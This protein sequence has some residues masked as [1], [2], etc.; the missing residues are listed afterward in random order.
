MNIRPLKLLPSVMIFIS[1]AVLLWIMTHLLIPFLTESTGWE[2]V[3]FWFISGGLGVFTPLIVA[4]IIMLHKEGCKFTK[5]LLVERLRFRPMTRRD[6]RFSYVALL[7]IGILTGG[8]MIA[9]QALVPDFNHTPSFMTLEPLSLGR[10]WLLLLWLPYWL[11]NIGS[12]E[13][14]WRGVILPRQEKAF[15]GK[16]WIIHGTGWVI[17]HIA[18]GWQLLVMLLPLLY[19]ESYVVQKTQNTWT[20]VFLHGAINGP[21]FIAIALGGI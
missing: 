13:F 21:G 4:G 3:I 1:A 11:L 19:I 2:S 20:G 10:Y 12:E 16:T 7:A 8:I 9:M 14:F 15:K 5:E 18:F 6:W 17:F